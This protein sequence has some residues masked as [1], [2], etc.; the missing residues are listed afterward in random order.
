VLLLLQILAAYVAVSMSV[1]LLVVAKLSKLI[2]A[3]SSSGLPAD[4]SQSP[5]H[6]SLRA[7]AHLR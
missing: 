3:E 7:T 4:S 1:G 2:R 6:G 5:D